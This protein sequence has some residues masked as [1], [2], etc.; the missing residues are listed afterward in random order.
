MTR[1]EAPEPLLE[2]GGNDGE[3]LPARF[4]LPCPCL[5]PAAKTVCVRAQGLVLGAR[6]SDS[7]DRW[8]QA[9]GP[10]SSGRA[11]HYPARPAEGAPSPGPS[12]RSSA[13]RM[14]SDAATRGGTAATSAGLQGLGAWIA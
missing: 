1:K 13:S 9:A 8:P 14:D 11:G 7:G 10:R 6:E 4:P 2:E 3:L 5:T 12:P